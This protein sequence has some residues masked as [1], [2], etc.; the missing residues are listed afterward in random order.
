MARELR[1]AALHVS[2]APGRSALN[3]E[4]VARGGAF[5]PVLGL[6]IGAVAAL[7]S[8]AGAA[9]APGDG[10]ALLGVLAL[11]VLSGG[12]LVRA[13]AR[14]ARRLVSNGGELGTA[15][16]VL[17]AIAALLLLVVEVVALRLT[18]ASARG[19]ALALAAMLGR[20]AFVVQAYGSRP[21]NQQGIG[22]AFTRAMQFRE[23]G[24]AS[25]SAMALTLLL[26][27]A[28]GLVLLLWTATQT[29]ALRILA[30]RRAGG[31]D[32]NDLAAGAALAEA[33]TLVW[34]ALLARLLTTGWKR[35]CHTS[36]RS[37]RAPPDR[38]RSSS[39]RA[40]ASSDAPTASSRS[41]S[42]SR[43]GS[44]TTPRRSGTSLSG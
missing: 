10:E 26:A 36:S 24:L 11:T 13:V 44:S 41:T 35:P 8:R 3:P 12:S 40:D 20:W 27:D 31:V 17:G 43:A 37:I 30:H 7:V 42:R 23:F 25:V 33:S 6:A 21:A 29:I 14:A 9:V 34:C 18:P 39:T 4:E 2:G 22:A 16:P 32:E 1:A 5:F 19:A 38:P 28:V 15:G